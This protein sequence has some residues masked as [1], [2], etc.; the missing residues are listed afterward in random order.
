MP[1]SFK[2]EHTLFKKSLAAYAVVIPTLLMPFAA[3]AAYPERPVKITISNG[4][5]GPVD[6]MSRML[7]EKLSEKWGQA[8]VVENRPGASGIIST[9]A[10]AKAS[11]DGYSL[12]MVV[13]STLT[14]VPFASSSLPFDPQN[15]L[16]PLSLVARTPFVFVVPASSPI[17]SWED[18]L[19]QS[20]K[21][22]IQR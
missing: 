5:G 13:S 21:S 16:Q 4:P 7:A 20:R 3:H 22:F 1:I 8:V 11:A 14:I 19:A 15:D 12:G 18:F 9:N 10:V 2:Q 6:I 17:K